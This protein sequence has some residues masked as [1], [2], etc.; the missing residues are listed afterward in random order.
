MLNTRAFQPAKQTAIKYREY[1]K[2][3]PLLSQAF[4]AFSDSELSESSDGVSTACSNA[5]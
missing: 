1:I 3:Y 5:E 4:F 2:G